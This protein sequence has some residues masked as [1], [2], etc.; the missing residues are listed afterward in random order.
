MNVKLPVGFG[1]GDQVG[2][3]VIGVPAQGPG[4]GEAIGLIQA[5]LRPVRN[6]LACLTSD[7]GPHLGVGL[8]ACDQII[9]LSYLSVLFQYISLCWPLTVRTTQR[10][11]IIVSPSQVFPL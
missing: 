3:F 9:A 5:D 11:S 10:S 2:T 6:L 1:V 7:Y 8:L 4:L